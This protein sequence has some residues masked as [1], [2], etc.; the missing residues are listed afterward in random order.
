MYLHTTLLLGLH[1][2]SF[3]QVRIS[4]TV[5]RHTHHLNTCPTILMHLELRPHSSGTNLMTLLSHR[6][7]PS[8][9]EHCRIYISSQLPHLRFCTTICGAP[10]GSH[11]AAGR[12]P[13]QPPLFPIS[14][15]QNTPFVPLPPGPPGGQHLHPLMQP[16]LPGLHAP[17]SFTASDQ[18]P[19]W[20]VP[21]PYYIV[22]QA[23]PPPV[24]NH[25]NSKVAKSDKFMGKDLRKLRSFI[26]SCVSCT[27]TTSPSSS[28][29]INN[30]SPMP[31]LSFQKSLYSGGSP[32]SWC[33]LNL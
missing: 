32:I 7:F 33:S 27:S 19:T 18:Y 14:G 8:Q 23:A 21:Y 29:M 12:M 30:E 25:H 17:P 15:H 31:H 6:A 3:E 26:S 24:Q 20:G 1:Q 5:H 2:H 10:S 28:R 16:S 11:F 9:P 22:Q 4:T 13:H